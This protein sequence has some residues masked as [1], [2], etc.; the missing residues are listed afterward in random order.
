MEVKPIDLEAIRLFQRKYKKK[1]ECLVRA[2]GRVNLIGEHT[3]YSEGYVLPVAIDRVVCIAMEKTDST[4]VR[5]YS[6]EMKDQI[7]FD[8]QKVEKATGWAEYIKGVAWALQEQGH[9]L[10]G[11]DGVLLS[12]IPRGAGLSSSAAVEMASVCAFGF[13]S[14][15]QLRKDQMA[16]I[17]RK[18][19][20]DWVGV[21]SGVMDQM[22]SSSGVAGHA[23]L[24]DCRSHETQTVPIPED[25]AIVVMDTATR[26]DL[27]KSAYNDRRR[28][29]EEAA[30]FFGVSYLRDV[31]IEE[32]NTRQAQLNP[33]LAKRARHVI[34]ENDRVLQFVQALKD[35]DET[36]LGKLLTASHSSLRDD[37]E[38]SSAELNEIVACAL[39]QAGCLGARMIGAGFGGCAIALVEKSAAIFFEKNIKK[40]YSNRTGLEA[41]IFICKASQGASIIK[42]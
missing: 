22:I 4:T 28:E 12:D 26:H 31:T 6:K 20:N 38:V 37:F 2:P 35:Q 24:I 1:P 7:H 41:T 39:E 42:L 40:C 3:D 29:C 23:L 17:G 36:A 9:G 5:L 8:V 11:W 32:F 34:T 25:I 21:K 16:L 15:I 27:V 30:R 19:E 10:K 13:S 33:I 18:A 14:D